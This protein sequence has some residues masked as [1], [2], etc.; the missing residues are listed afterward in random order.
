MPTDSA[1]SYIIFTEIN[2]L[3]SVSWIEALWYLLCVRGMSGT[4]AEMVF[5]STFFKKKKSK[6]SQIDSK[7]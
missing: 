2:V 1:N 6:N 5:T 7:A 3:A 4:Q